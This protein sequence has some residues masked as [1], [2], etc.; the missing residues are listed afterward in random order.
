MESAVSCTLQVRS[1]SFS[2]MPL[3]RLTTQK[4]LS[5]IHDMNIAPKPMEVKR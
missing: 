2:V 4:P 1:V 3:R 5:F